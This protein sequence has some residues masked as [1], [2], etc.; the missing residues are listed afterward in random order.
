MI[1]I[2]LCVSLRILHHFMKEWSQWS[3]VTRCIV[4]RTIEAKEG[5]SQ[6]WAID[7]GIK[8][9]ISE[10]VWSKL[11]LPTLF[12]YKVMNIC[13]LYFLMYFRVFYSLF[14]P[15]S[16]FHICRHWPPWSISY[17]I[18]III[19]IIHLNNSITPRL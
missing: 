8:H 4:H 18:T 17:H 2:Q 9:S 13:V 7:N 6:N 19:F 1:R 16:Q 15:V 11:H 5:I 14:L 3:L 10:F 12:G